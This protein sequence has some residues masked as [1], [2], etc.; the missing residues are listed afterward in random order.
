LPPDVTE[1]VNG[2]KKDAKARGFK[3]E[4]SRLCAELIRA[5][6][7]AEELKECLANEVRNDP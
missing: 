7:E 6:K 2:L 1:Y 5:K 3:F 4:L